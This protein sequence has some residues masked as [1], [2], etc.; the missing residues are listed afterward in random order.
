MDVALARDGPVTVVSPAGD[1]DGKSAP[2]FQEAVLSALDHR[3]NVLLDLGGVHFMS[4]AGLRV[5]LLVYRQAMARKARVALCGL[6]TEIRR[7]MSATGFLSFF[8]VHATRKE[9]L[10]ALE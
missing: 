10:A 2:S 1:I 5:L 3:G 9:G 4:S 7:T 8:T 6:S